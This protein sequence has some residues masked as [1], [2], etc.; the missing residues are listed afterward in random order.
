MRSQ[1]DRLQIAQVFTGVQYRVLSVPALCP[2]G[3]TAAV[4]AHDV[5]HAD[6]KGVRLFLYS[7]TL[8]LTT[9][10]GNVIISD[11]GIARVCD[12]GLA[13]VLEDDPGSAIE[14]SVAGTW[15]YMAFEVN[16]EGRYTPQS[17][18]WACG[19]LLIEVS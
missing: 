19:C 11:H 12:F 1:A 4:H 15:P 7:L 9:V 18:I 16:T 8:I 5:V 6:L 13:V 3:E 14:H 2:S 17:D 10:K